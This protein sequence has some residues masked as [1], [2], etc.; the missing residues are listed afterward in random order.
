MTDLFCTFCH[1]G[2]NTQLVTLHTSKDLICRECHKLSHNEQWML[3]L[4]VRSVSPWS[5][6]GYAQLFH[7]GLLKERLLTISNDLKRDDA[8]AQRYLKRM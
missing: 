7:D 3:S 6:A 8:L 4:L 2:E 1:L 5:F